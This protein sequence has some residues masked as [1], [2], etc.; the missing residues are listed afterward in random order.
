MYIH[1]LSMNI[2][3]IHT[4]TY[5]CTIS[6]VHV[7]LLF[8]FVE[9]ASVFKEIHSKRGNCCISIIFTENTPEFPKVTVPLDQRVC[10]LKI[11]AQKARVVTLSNQ[12]SLI[13]CR[14]W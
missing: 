11:A 12:K 4:C 10:D 13:K 6:H 5:I 2:E 14:L 1:I 7:P 9:L 3:Y 8:C